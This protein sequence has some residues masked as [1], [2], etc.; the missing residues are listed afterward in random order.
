MIIG[1]EKRP[2][3]NKK[4]QLIGPFSRIWKPLTTGPALQAGK[5]LYLTKM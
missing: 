4:G 2:C 5:L 3:N 1:A